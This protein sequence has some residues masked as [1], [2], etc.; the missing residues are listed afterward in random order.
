MKLDDLGT[1]IC[2]MG[3]SSSGKSTLAQAIGRRCGLTPIHLDQ[4][5]H[6]PNTDWLPRPQEEFAALHD[7]AV[8]GERWVIEGNYSKLLPRRL[9]RATGLILLDLST[10]ASLFRYLRRC[11]FDSNRHGALEGARD[12][13]NWEMM[14]HIAVVT[15]ANRVRYEQIFKDVRLPKIGLGS[16]RAVTSF[17]RENGLGR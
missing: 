7:H 3:P 14:H 11:W 1:R 10:A 5:Y 16:A 4:L 9:E 17:Y 12:R 15:R 8:A 2:I 13:V 6:L